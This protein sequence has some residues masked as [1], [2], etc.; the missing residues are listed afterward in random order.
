MKRS[1]L[2]V[3]VSQASN[4]I[5]GFLH[6]DPDTILYQV[7]MVAGIQ[8][9]PVVLSNGST[10]NIGEFTTKKEAFIYKDPS[11][12]S[13]SRAGSRRFY[14]LIGTSPDDS[15]IIKGAVD[16]V[17]SA[18][19]P[20]SGEWIETGFSGQYLSESRNFARYREYYM[21]LT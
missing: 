7:I 5:A 12:T 9:I 6:V 16:G 8:K 19:I 1:Y 13:I 20:D 21:Y 14:C 11:A 2:P 10:V 15:S 4:E 18:K 3:F 17:D